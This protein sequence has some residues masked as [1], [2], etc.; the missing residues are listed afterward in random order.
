[1]GSRGRRC[2]VSPQVDWL[3]IVREGRPGVG[4]PRVPFPLRLSEAP[5]RCGGVVFEIFERACGFEGEAVALGRLR[6]SCVASRPRVS[7]V[8]GTRWVYDAL[9][10]VL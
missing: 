5:C 6:V 1:M 2:L 10:A 7:R 3:W 4:L 9:E 8:A